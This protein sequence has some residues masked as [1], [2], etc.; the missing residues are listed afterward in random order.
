MKNFGA[1]NMVLPLKKVLMKKP[2]N[3]MSKVDLQKWN[4][5]QPMDQRKLNTSLDNPIDNKLNYLATKLNPFFCKLF[6]IIFL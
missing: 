1:Q 6:S 3:F 4:Y 5:I 2:Q